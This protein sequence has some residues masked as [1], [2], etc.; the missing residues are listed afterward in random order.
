M[1]KDTGQIR[2]GMCKDSCL[3]FETVPNYSFT[4]EAQDGGGKVSSVNLFI[5]VVDVNDNA[6]KFTKDS[7]LVDLMEDATEFASPVFVKVCSV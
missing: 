7:Y 2:I 3:D 4:Y 1:E 5:Q 6:P